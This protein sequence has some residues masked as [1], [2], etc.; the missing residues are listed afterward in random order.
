MFL[1]IVIISIALF[2]LVCCQKDKMEN[3]AGSTTATTLTPISNEAIQN[4]AGLYNKDNL[5][6]SNLTTGGLNATDAKVT[7]TTGTNQL[8][9][10]TIKLGNK[11]IITSGKDGWG[12]DDD[13]LR[14]GKA[15]GS[16]AY[17]GG[18]AGNKLWASD[19]LYAGSAN[20]NGATTIGGAL[21]VNNSATVHGAVNIAGELRAGNRY[22][23]QR[24]GM[25]CAGYDMSNGQIPG[26]GSVQECLNRCRNASFG[27]DVGAATRR[28]SDG[29]C[30][31]KTGCAGPNLDRQFDSI[32][33]Y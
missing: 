15:D 27:G 8:N 23:S 22:I 3:M 19:S 31:C 2:I 6:L 28:I 12:Y 25:N 10:N 18:F 14:L 11:W 26:T 5:T 21:T 7:N 20:I 16:A 30:W 33:T 17:G 32:I 29:Y 4:I 24:N 1:F 13:W 9:A